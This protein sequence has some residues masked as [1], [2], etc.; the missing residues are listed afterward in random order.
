MAKLKYHQPNIQLPTQTILMQERQR[1]LL[2]I[3]GKVISR[4][5]AL[6]HH[7]PL[8]Q[9][10]SQVQPLH[11]LKQNLFTMTPQRLLRLQLKMV[12]L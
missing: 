3:R 9:N 8:L 5:T 7:L 11:Y 10:P 6:M 2:Q 12:K 1:L 4:L